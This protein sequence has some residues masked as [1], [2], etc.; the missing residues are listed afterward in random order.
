[1]KT[2]K[3]FSQKKQLL[4]LEFMLD[5]SPQVYSKIPS[6]ILLDG[7]KGYFLL[8]GTIWEDTGRLLDLKYVFIF[9]Q[10]I[11]YYFR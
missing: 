9:K 11:G 1:M 8:T 10:K 2:L 4:H 3:T 7:V 5:N 6:S